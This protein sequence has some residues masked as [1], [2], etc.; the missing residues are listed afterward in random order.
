MH[1][2]IWYEKDVYYLRSFEE[3]FPAIVYNDALTSEPK[4]LC[5]F[6]NQFPAIVYH[7]ALTSKVVVSSEPTKLYRIDGG[8]FIENCE[9]YAYPSICVVI[10]SAGY[11]YP[12]MCEVLP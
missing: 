9:G 8:D 4:V 5:D 7:D 3:E 6:E 1:G 2:K 11:A 10:G 12:D